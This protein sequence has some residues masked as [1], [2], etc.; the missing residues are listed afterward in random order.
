[1]AAMMY[2]FNKN[3]IDSLRDEHHNEEQK[4][5]GTLAI[6][7]GHS[8]GKIKRLIDSYKDK[9][10]LSTHRS[11]IVFN[12]SIN[13]FVESI[14]SRDY[15][16]N[17]ICDPIFIPNYG[18]DMRMYGE[19]V[20]NYAFDDYFFINDD[21]T[22]NDGAWFSK[23]KE[24][25]EDHDLIGIQGVTHVRT[26]FYGCKRKLWLANYCLAAS[27]MIKYKFGSRKHKI[28]TINIGKHI[29][30]AFEYGTIWISD[31]LNC[32]AF[33]MKP[34][35]IMVDSNCKKRRRIEKEF[36]D[37]IDRSIRGRPHR[38]WSNPILGNNEPLTYDHILNCCEYAKKSLDDEHIE[39]W[40]L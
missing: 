1:M 15:P 9:T 34:P 17:L 13:A 10:D 39:R 31:R 8:V 16:D 29:A 19:A 11:A 23:Y 35:N 3:A 38:A 28:A 20:L 2:Y 33:K 21:S 25:L 4:H 36:A 32:E 37:F 30:Y 5:D 26:S 12:G 24:A 6:L 27:R 40:R 14:N 22:I 7:T 18:W